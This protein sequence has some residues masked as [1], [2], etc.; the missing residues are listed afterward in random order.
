MRCEIATLREQRGDLQNQ[1]A[2][3]E[4]SQR[5]LPPPSVSEASDEEVVAARYHDQ[6]EDLTKANDILTKDVVKH[7]QEATTTR[8]TFQTKNLQI[9]HKLTV[10]ETE[11]KRLAALRDAEKKTFAK[12]LKDAQKSGSEGKHRI[13]SELKALKDKHTTQ[14]K[15]LRDELKKTQEEHEEYLSKLMKVLEKTT[16]QR[17]RESKKVKKELETITRQKE[18]EIDT[19]KSELDKLRTFHDIKAGKPPKL[20]T[21]GRTHLLRKRLERNSDARARRS[22]Q[23]DDVVQTMTSILG[24]KGITDLNTN[25][26]ATITIDQDNAESITDMI[27]M[28]TDLYR[29]EEGS[30]T[31]KDE[32]SLDLIDEYV[33]RSEPEKSVFDMQRRLQY[34]NNELESLKLEIDKLNTKFTK[35]CPQCKELNNAV[36]GDSIIYDDDPIIY[37]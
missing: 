21:L 37:G 12:A 7:R 5:E 19:L 14:V 30:Q 11:C 4:N 15:E 10:A 24:I 34:S 23:F 28:L 36:D 1:L 2:E 13:Q 33:S 16:K 26:T 17:E 9:N 27:D 6:I 22:A 3:A 31:Y 29:Q 32:A 25:T 35:M 8:R 18:R 20:P